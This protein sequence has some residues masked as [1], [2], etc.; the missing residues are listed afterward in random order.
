[1]SEK[2]PPAAESPEPAE[3]QPLP[4]P[5][6]EEKLPPPPPPHLERRNPLVD[7]WAQFRSLGL[8]FVDNPWNALLAMI[9]L[10]VRFVTGVPIDRFSRITP[11]LYVSGQY[12]KRG[13]EALKKR[14]IIAIVNLRTEYDD[15]AA[16][17][18][19]PHYL[20]LKTLDN[21]PPTMEQLKQAVDFIHDE[22]ERGGKVYVHCAAGV[23]RAPTLAAAYLVSTGLSPQDAWAKIKK[24]RP[25]IRP[26]QAQRDQVERY[27]ELLHTQT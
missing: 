4:P 21:T 19:F 15:A 18:A 13:M 7:L 5:P 3:P 22:I 2:L 20:H 23:G 27:A 24:V 14:G 9:E 25:F 26:T 6:P 17:I 12:R 1:M 16:G 8:A 11:E 10:I